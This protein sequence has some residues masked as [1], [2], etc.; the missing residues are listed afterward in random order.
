MPEFEKFLASAPA[1]VRQAYYR[2]GIT[3]TLSPK[4]VAEWVG[5]SRLTLALWRHKRVGPAY[6][7]FD[8]VIRYKADDVENWMHEGSDHD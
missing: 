1:V 2:A 3:P 5:V 6:L 7:K 8:R 4:Q